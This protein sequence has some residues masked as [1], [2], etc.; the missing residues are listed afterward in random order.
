V[1]GLEITLRIIEIYSFI[2]FA[3]IIVSWI[4]LFTQRPIDMS[5]PLVRFLFDVTE[6]LLAPIRR[7]ALIG[8]IDLSPMVAIFTLIIIRGILE[9]SIG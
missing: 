6:P 1:S 5:N 3:R 7:F 4:P 2:I 8:Q 9:S